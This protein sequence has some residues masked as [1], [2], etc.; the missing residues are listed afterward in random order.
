[1]S[2]HTLSPQPDLTAVKRRQQQTWASGDYGAGWNYEAT[3]TYFAA[4]PAA[5]MADLAVAEVGHWDAHH[6][7]NGINDALLRS[8]ADGRPGAI[9]ELA[10]Y[11]GVRSFRS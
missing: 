6:A 3:L 5:P 10:Q 1:M 4:N 9:D 8:H 2:I 11:C 7:S